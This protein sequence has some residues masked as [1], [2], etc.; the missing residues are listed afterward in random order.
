MGLLGVPERTIMWRKISFIYNQTWGQI[1][2]YLYLKVF[3]YFFFKYLY[4]YLYLSFPK[5][6]V[7]VFVIKYI[8]KVFDISNTIQIHFKYFCNLFFY[9]ILSSPAILLMPPIFYSVLL[10]VNWDQHPM[11]LHHSHRNELLFDGWRW[12]YWSWCNQRDN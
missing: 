12:V 11:V 10:F 3:K 7:F 1:Q 5:W 2:K 9:H 6:K 4:L 8:Q